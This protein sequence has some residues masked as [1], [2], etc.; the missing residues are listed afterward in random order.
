[1]RERLEAVVSKG[2]LAEER[3][4]VQELDPVDVVDDLDWS[5]CITK[6]STE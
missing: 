2:D 4:C 6:S 1:M 5:D 3:R